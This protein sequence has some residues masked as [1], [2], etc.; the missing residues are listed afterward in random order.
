VQTIRQATEFFRFELRQQLRRPA[1]W[2]SLLACVAAGV[3]LASTRM[4]ELEVAAGRVAQNVPYAVLRNLAALSAIGMFVVLV[5]VA[6]AALQDFASGAGP[7]IFSR[8]VRTTGYLAGRLAGGYCVGAL[9]VLAGVVA[10]AITQAWLAVGNPQMAPVSFSALSFGVLVL[11]LPNLLIVASLVF[12]LALSSRSMGVTFL[13]LLLITVGQDLAEII[14][15][16]SFGYHV[17]ALLDP[18]G[19][20]ALNSVTHTWTVSD[21]ARRFPGLSGDLMWNRLL[22]LCLTCFFCLLSGPIFAR[23]ARRADAGEKRK[24]LKFSAQ[25]APAIP[26]Q[27]PSKSRLASPKKGMSTWLAQCLAILRFELGCTLRSL[28]WRVLVVCGMIAAFYGVMQGHRLQGVLSIPSGPSIAFAIDRAAR[29]IMT[30]MVVLYCG[31]LVWRERTTRMDLTLDALPI[32]RGVMVVG[33]LL[34]LV[35]LIAG[36]VGLLGA[37]AL[38]SQLAHGGLA[39]PP[40]AVLIPVLHESFGYLH[41]AAVA[42]LLQVL[43]GDRLR[44]YL[45]MGL[46]LSLRLGLKALGN[47]GALYSIADVRLPFL[48]EMNG[49]AYGLQRV[50]LLQGY[51]TWIAASLVMVASLFWPHGVALPWRQ[52][53][54]RAK[55]RNTGWTF[56]GLMFCVAGSTASAVWIQQSTMAPGMGWSKNQIES[57]QAHYEEKFQSW[58]GRPRPAVVSVVADVDLDPVG[59]QVQI[60]GHYVLE[61]QHTLPVK[62]MLVNFDPDF[63]LFEL[64]LTTT[65]GRTAATTATTATSTQENFPGTRVM[66]FDPPLAPGDTLNLEFDLKFH[67]S[68]LGARPADRWLVENGSYFLGGTG[69]HPFFLGAQFFPTL[70]YDTARALRSR[71]T[72][73]KFGL[74]PWAPL[75]SATAYEARRASATVEDS[76]AEVFGSS[77]WA[78]VDLWI[79]TPADQTALAPGELL[80]RRVEDGRA[81]HHFR[82]SKKIQAFFSILCGRYE[83]VTAQQ[84][85]VTLEIY[86]HAAHAARVAHILWA[87]QRSLAYFEE[88]WGPYPHQVL[89]LGEIPGEAGFAASF[90]GVMGFGEGMAFTSPAGDGQALQFPS[91]GSAESSAT[92]MDPILW[93]VAHEVAHQWW[94]GHVLPALA[95]GASFTSESLAQYGSLAVMQEEYGDD[96]SLRMA[97]YNLEMYLRGRSRAGREERALVDVDD[98]EYLHYGKGM[99]AFHAMAKVVGYEVI[100]RALFRVVKNFGGPAG[101]P[102]TSIN[103]MEA[104]EAQWP[105]E[106]QAM[107]EELLRKIVFVESSVLS[108][109]VQ[110]LPHQKFALV[111]EGLVSAVEADGNGVEQAFHYEGVIELLVQFGDGESSRRIVAEVRDGRVHFEMLCEQQPTHVRLDPRLLHMDRNLADNEGIVIE[112][113]P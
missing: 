23:R 52:S 69:S 31:E 54:A 57:F 88:H 62:E 22:W 100:D 56:A 16:S 53:L 17:P 96:V 21:Y 82:T 8:P 60:H 109:E 75:I 46:F 14:P 95:L 39:V 71:K 7:L 104:L 79:H 105:A 92:A 9:A 94:D 76:P 74:L 48:S 47:T 106:H 91:A 58:N 103:L 98:Q 42:L 61:N 99:V 81:H 80:E 64:S 1:F 5:S 93:I 55:R 67:P 34:A 89:R 68:G 36:S 30:L 37:A 45:A 44:G 38:V 10:M 15:V 26:V 59:R 27:A 43:A 84:G 11:V 32:A 2:I 33:K 6:K 86:Y 20:A 112:R 78:Q 102:I 4:G 65:P 107:L 51:G 77:D 72:R 13:G 28:A 12:L 3:L 113:N 18:L 35:L 19:I 25:K 40:S 110:A 97:K 108:A 29:L 50:V 24:A 73:E 85:D 49:W 87:L 111:V 41:L 66:Q 90:P 70:G 63:T 101:K 83:K